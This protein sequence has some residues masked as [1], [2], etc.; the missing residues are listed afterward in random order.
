[1]SNKKNL[2]TLAYAKKFLNKK[3]LDLF[4]KN[5]QIKSTN[6]FKSLSYTVLSSLILIIIFFS[7]PLIVNFKNNLIIQSTEVTNSSKN[8]LENVLTGKTIEDEQNDELDILQIF[9]DIFE[10]E[11]ISTSSVRL[12]ASTIEQ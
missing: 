8:K 7:S 3:G 6:S 1:M 11:D 2:F 5:N 12:S 4:K 10:Y 9:E